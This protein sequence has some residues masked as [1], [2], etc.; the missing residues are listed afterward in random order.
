MRRLAVLSILGMAAVATA[1]TAVA[2]LAPPETVFAV[3]LEPGR[4]PAVAGEQLPL[5]VVLDIEPGWHVN[6]A[7]P[8]DEFS[9]PTSLAWR[10]PEGWSDPAVGFPEGERL[11]FEFS[12][13]PI[14]VWHDRVVIPA[15]VTVPANA[16]GTVDLAVEVTAQACNDR[17]CLPP[18]PV[19]ASVDVD[20]APSGT[21]SRRVNAE[22]FED[23]SA[24]GAAAPAD[25]GDGL[26]GRLASSSLVLQVAVV[27]LVGLGLAFTPCVY[28][29]IPI[30]VGF[31][32]QQAKDRAG[33]GT[34]SLAV[35]YVLGI[36]V[37]Y[38]A[39]GVL[40]ALTG[41]LFGSLM[42]SPW[43]IAGIVV[44]LLALAASMFGLWE[45]RP[46][47]W[48]MR[49]SGGRSGYLGALL[50]GL[51][52]GVVAAPCVGPAVVGLLTYIGQTGDPVLGFTLFFALSVGLGL[53]YLVL[54]TFTGALNK[55]P[56]SGMWMVGVRK[57]FGVLLIA[58]AAYFARPVLPPGAGDW[59][60]ALSLGLGALYI[61]VVDRT[62]HEQPAIDRV[63]RV[64]AAAMIVLAV[65]QIPHGDPGEAADELAWQAYAPAAFEQAVA[66]GEP[67]IVDFY[68]DWC[69]PCRE[70]DERTFADPRVGEALS[71][72]A[73]FKVDQ[74]RPN[75][76]G[77]QAAQRFGVLGMPTVIVLD[78]ERERFRIT[79]FEPP[80]R[81]LERLQGG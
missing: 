72:Y 34:F 38:S 47:A 37:T 11:R 44:V 5:A 61:L 46:P 33:R 1:A 64:V 30:T 50:M 28:P 19:S 42:Q 53:P 71:G 48:A 20:L 63:M 3:A 69:A 55:L 80:E 2:Q 17:Q 14:E 78:G 16:T 58:L 6:S 7:D 32:A 26:A 23:A 24:G 13:E 27:F 68:A 81:F 75:P 35:V 41:R 45:I 25:A 70:L 4:S 43:V 73:R 36:A 77:D 8:G 65:L 31:F 74:T 21:V 62:G 52:V 51:V 40:A 56:A 12:D 49:M 39:L 22:L 76:V 60:I 54:G 59:L 9:V 10:M 18:V 67:V 79:G 66:S 15:V 57:V 29:L